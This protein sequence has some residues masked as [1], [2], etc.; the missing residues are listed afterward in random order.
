MNK[1][2][3]NVKQKEF[4]S[5]KG[6]TSWV[7]DK[8]NMDKMLYDFGAQA[9]KQL[10]LNI[11]D[12]VLDIGCGTGKT[13]EIISKHVGDNGSVTGVDISELMIAHA[14]EVND[15]NNIQNTIYKVMDV[16][17][18]TLCASLFNHAY[19]RFGVMFF[20]QPQLAFKNI[21]NA[22]RPKGSLSFICWQGPQENPWHSVTQKII[23]S[24]FDLPPITDI[25]APSPFAFQEAEYIR[26]TLKTVNFSNI[27]I[28]PFK[29]EMI[30]FEG[31]TVE[32]AAK[33][34]LERNPIIA[35]QILN[36]SQCKIEEI[37]NKLINSYTQFYSDGLKFP[38]AAWLVYG[39]K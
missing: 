4:W 17:T 34:M 22:L 23:G 19:S 6:G 37:I 35:E 36:V 24:Y 26:E 33:A 7:S 21:Y 15:Q 8:K 10:N 27:E 2:E 3:S 1:E 20:D 9:L 12:N 5:G 25:R 28:K 13:T 32:Y 16:Q 31:Q 39:E 11:G 30:W 38:S 18:D 14:K 29:T